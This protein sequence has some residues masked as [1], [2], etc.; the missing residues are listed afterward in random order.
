MVMQVVEINNQ[1]VQPR[2]I[3]CYNYVDIF[4]DT[5]YESCRHNC[6]G[7][8]HFVPDVQFTVYCNRILCMRVLYYHKCLSFKN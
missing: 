6:Y 8:A 4:S 3:M 5:V 7:V 1:I 2:G